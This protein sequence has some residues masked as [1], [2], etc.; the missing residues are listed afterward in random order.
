MTVDR[1]WWGFSKQHGWVVLDR[2]IPHNAVRS[3]NELLFLRCSDS[4]TYLVKRELWNPPEYRYAPNY[5]RDHSDAADKAQ[6]EFDEVMSRWP[7][8]RIALQRQS[9]IMERDSAQQA[10]VK[11]RKTTSAAAA[12]RAQAASDDDDE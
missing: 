1:Q 10:P 6:A 8:M 7:E 4:K 2:D 11:K 9:D 12:E 5:I 3:N